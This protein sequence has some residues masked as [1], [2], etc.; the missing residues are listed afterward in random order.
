MEQDVHIQLLDQRSQPNCTNNREGNVPYT[1]KVQDSPSDDDDDD[2]VIPPDHSQ[3][4]DVVS[5]APKVDQNL[6][7]PEL[8]YKNLKYFLAVFSIA[9]A[10]K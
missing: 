3:F 7:Q 1:G 2:D 8:K 10:C 4:K 5:I 9:Q 6:E